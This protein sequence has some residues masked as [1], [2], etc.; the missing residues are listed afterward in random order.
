MVDKVF[1]FLR[2]SRVGGVSGGMD[3]V[4]L[5]VGIM[6]KVSGFI[7]SLSSFFGIVEGV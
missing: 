3:K 5:G 1:D 4:G 2:E 7:I 6:K